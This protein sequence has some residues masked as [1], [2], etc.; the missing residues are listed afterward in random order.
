M[1]P[2]RRCSWRWAARARR[3]ACAA[4]ST[5]AA[6]A[7]STKISQEPLRDE[8]RRA[9]S[10]TSPSSPARRSTGGCSTDI[11][12]LR[13]ALQDLHRGRLL[14][15]QGPP[16]I[17]GEHPLGLALDIVPDESIGG[18]WG[19]INRLARWAEPR[20]NRPRA[21]FRWVGYW[22]DKRHGPRDHLHLSWDHSPTKPEARRANRGDD[23]VSR[24]VSA[25]PR[26]AGAGRRRSL[27]ALPAARA[28][29][30]NPANDPQAAERR[31]SRATTTTT[32]RRCEPALD[33]G[34]PAADEVGRPPLPR[35]VLGRLPLPEALEGH[36]AACIPRAARSTGASTPAA[37]A[38]AAPPTS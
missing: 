4:R 13:R 6:H 1:A 3:A 32:R 34:H 19:D 17:N 18:D 11:E 14:D 10:S 27:L 9:A 7:G 29:W 8:R 24:L 25:A 31:R 36:E 16:A 33:A 26:H 20:Q 21:P 35:R 37:S 22:G 15:R 38:S 28:A 2:Q 12:Y 30:P 5:P 23:Q